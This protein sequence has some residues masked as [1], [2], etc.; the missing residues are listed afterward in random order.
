M[1]GAKRPVY[2]PF[3]LVGIGQSFKKGIFGIVGNSEKMNSMHQAEE[4]LG[5]AALVAK[6]LQ[7]RENGTFPFDPFNDD[8]GSELIWGREFLEPRFVDCL[9]VRPF[10]KKKSLPRRSAEYGLHLRNR[11]WR[12]THA[13]SAL[14]GLKSIFSS[15]RANHSQ[16]H[17][18]CD[19]TINWPLRSSTTRSSDSS[20]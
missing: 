13:F 14:H 19:A 20:N 6:P 3:A 7:S 1:S 12:G 4:V 17:A 11:F 10:N 9:I 5:V 2:I 8:F 18:E 15:S 16:T